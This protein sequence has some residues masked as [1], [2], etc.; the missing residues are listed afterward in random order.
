MSLVRNF[1]GE[2][3]HACHSF[4]AAETTGASGCCCRRRSPV[5]S[6]VSGR[7]FCH[8][9][10]H[11]PSPLGFQALCNPTPS[12]SSPPPVLSLSLGLG[13]ASSWQ[14][15]RSRSSYFVPLSSPCWCPHGRRV[16]YC[17]YRPHLLGGMSCSLVGR[18]MDDCSLPS[19]V[20][21]S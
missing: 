17:S 20:R 16:Y 2:T 15:S 10:A 12:P 11:P 9:R 6:H 8:D 13:Q 3:R 14:L 21:S 1:T 5:S 18:A 7:S 19:V 4:V